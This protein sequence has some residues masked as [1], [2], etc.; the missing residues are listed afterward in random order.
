MLVVNTILVAVLCWL[1]YKL[2]KK[3]AWNELCRDYIVFH[4]TTKF[5]PIRVIL[6]GTLISDG[7]RKDLVV[8]KETKK[9]ENKY[10]KKSVKSNRHGKKTSK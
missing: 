2:G 4:K 5:R 3:H 10:A 6:G 8:K 7:G 9:K 1:F